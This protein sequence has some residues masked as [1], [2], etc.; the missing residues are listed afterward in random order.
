MALPQVALW[1]ANCRLI[2]QQHFQYGLVPLST[3]GSTYTHHSRLDQSGAKNASKD[4]VLNNN[5]QV[6]SHAQSVQCT[7]T[8]HTENAGRGSHAVQVINF[9]Q[10]A[11]TATPGGVRL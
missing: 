6:L 10:L 11:G 2:R 4:A 3:R 5:V 1:R 9:S 8:H 7:A